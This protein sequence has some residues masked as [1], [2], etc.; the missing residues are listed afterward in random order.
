MESYTV[1][2]R[3]GQEIRGWLGRFERSGEF[4]TVSMFT[5][6]VVEAVSDINKLDKRV[7]F[8]NLGGLDS[9]KIQIIRH[10]F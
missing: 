4:V 3:F 9:A 5:R 2:A 6:K 1:C 8:G 10:H 7:I